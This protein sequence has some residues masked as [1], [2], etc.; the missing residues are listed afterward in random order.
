MSA[1]ARIERVR[2][3]V[4]LARLRVLISAFLGDREIQVPLGAARIDLS[5]LMKRTNRLAEISTIDVELAQRGYVLES[6]LIFRDVAQ[7]RFRHLTITGFARRTRQRTI[8][9]H[10]INHRL[11]NPVSI[12]VCAPFIFFSGPYT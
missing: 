9:E 1:F 2:A 11:R 8:E 12:A 6:R 7:R 3:S 4:V 5:C 10:G